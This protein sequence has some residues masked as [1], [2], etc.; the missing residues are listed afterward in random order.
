MHNQL[1]TRWLIP[2][3]IV[4]MLSGLIYVT[5]QQNY[6]MSFNDPQ[7]QLAEDAVNDLSIGKSADL[8]VPAV[9][10]DISKSLT[11]FLVIYDQAGN[12]IA[13]SGQLHGK[14]PSLPGGVLDYTKTHDDNRLTWQPEKGIRN[15]IV[16][17]QYKEPSGKTGYVMAGR[18]MREL[19]KREKQTLLQ[20]LAV[21]L[22]TLGLIVIEDVALARLGKK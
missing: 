14:L 3:T 21:W 9:P 1:L 11:P 4:T 19:E 16:V 6:R 7:I 18:S 8:I 20:A 17:K 15:A 13:G 12:P 22:L 10:V 2:V 5:V